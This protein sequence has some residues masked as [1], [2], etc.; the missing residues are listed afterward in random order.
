[1][2][3]RSNIIVGVGKDSNKEKMNLALVEK[4][5]IEV[6]K[7]VANFIHA[8]NENFDRTKIEQKEVSVIWFRTLTKNAKKIGESIE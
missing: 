4:Q 7:E 8:E 3:F 2:D 5:T 1:M 6:C